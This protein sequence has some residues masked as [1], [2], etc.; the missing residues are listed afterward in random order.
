MTNNNYVNAPREQ[1]KR[2]TLPEPHN[3]TEPREKSGCGE[4]RW[5][6]GSRMKEEKSKLK[7][8]NESDDRRV[9]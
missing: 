1:G 9:Q 5:G 3:V 4:G 8:I 2:P 6:G 7:I